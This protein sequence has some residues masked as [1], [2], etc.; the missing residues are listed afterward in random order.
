MKH[1]LLAACLILLLLPT[2]LPALA[3]GAEPVVINNA[4]GL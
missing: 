1:R 4:V 3:D 2:P